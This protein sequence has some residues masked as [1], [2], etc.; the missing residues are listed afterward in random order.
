MKSGSKT[1]QLGLKW[2][3]VSSFISVN[4][5]CI[6][7]RLKTMDFHGMKLPRVFVILV[8]VWMY[9]SDVRLLFELSSISRS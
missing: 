2:L 7:F 4:L 3:A 1:I 9:L 8:S 6:Y 5:T